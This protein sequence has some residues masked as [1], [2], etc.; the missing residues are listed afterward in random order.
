M[1]ETQEKFQNRLREVLGVDDIVIDWSSYHRTPPAYLRSMDPGVCSS[2]ANLISDTLGY[3]EIL[4]YNSL[5]D[6]CKKKNNLCVYQNGIAL[7][8]S[9]NAKPYVVCY[10]LDGKRVPG[11]KDLG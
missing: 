5:R 8:I 11:F 9:A 10:K 2:F 6:L 1:T 7:K 3:R 4:F